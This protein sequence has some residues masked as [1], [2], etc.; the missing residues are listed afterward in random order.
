MINRSSIWRQCRGRITFQDGR[1]CLVAKADF[2]SL[3]SCVKIKLQNQV[4]RVKT[5]EVY[6]QFLLL[7]PSEIR[8]K[9]EE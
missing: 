4:P 1:S 8:L 7:S 2:F 5:S 3:S 9:E 6:F